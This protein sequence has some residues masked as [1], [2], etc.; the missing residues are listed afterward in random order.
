MGAGVGGNTIQIGD[1]QPIK[2]G[3]LAK[4]ITNYYL[5][6]KKIENVFKYKNSSQNN[7][8]YLSEWK[9]DKLY[10]LDYDWIRSWKVN[11]KYNDIKHELDQIYSTTKRKDLIKSLKMHCQLS[12]N[13]NILINYEDS[14]SFGPTSYSIFMSNN[15]LTLEDLDCLVD[16]ETYL[17]FKEMS[18]WNRFGTEIILEGIIS[19]KMIILFFNDI[20]IV[21]ILYNGMI[22]DKNEELIQL[23]AIAYHFV[24]ET[25]D[26][27]AEKT[28]LKYNKLKK[29]LKSKGENNILNIFE[30]QAIGY[31]EEIQLPIDGNDEIKI[32]NENLKSRNSRSIMQ[33]N[34]INQ[35][36]INFNNVNRERLIGLENVGATCY[37]NATLQCFINI[38]SL[39]QYLL[40]ESV[41]KQ[42]ENSDDDLYGLSKAY[43]HL[44]EKVCLDDNIKYYYAPREFKRVIS[45][46]NPLFQ[47]INAN[48]SKDLINFL[49]EVLNYE[50]S[51]FYCSKKDNYAKNS[52]MMD[53]TNMM[54]ILDNFRIEFTKNNKSIIAQN[55]FFILQ[56]NTVCNG[57][58]MLKYNF[59]SLF[60][61]EFPLEL[62]YNYSLSQ[63]LP[64]INNQGKKC[65]NL[66]T[67]FEHYGLPSKFTGENQ[68]YCNNCK[69]LRDAECKNILFSLPPVL[70]LIL[71]RGKGKSFDCDVDFPEFLN[72]QNF[73]NYKKSI[74]EYRLRGVISHLGES[75]MSGHFIAYCRHR[76]NNKWYCYNDATVTECQD[77]KNG[78]MNGTPY[79]LFYETINNQSNVLFDNVIDANLI[80][81]NMN[82]FNNDI[83]PFFNNLNQANNINL[84][85]NGI[86]LI[87]TN[88][89]NNFS[90]DMQMSNQMIQN[91]IN[92][93]NFNNI[94]NEN[95]N[96][97]SFQ[98]GNNLNNFRNIN[99]AQNNNSNLNIITNNINNFNNNF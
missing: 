33:S 93:F 34:Q 87:N 61:L 16:E 37:M 84:N 15:K 44:L 91:N 66:L 46:K 36:V 95:N 74:Y 29:L 60:L 51:Q 43:C 20:Q 47:G 78:F 18:F 92:N 49:L 97:I 86:N 26:F 67:C 98:S 75:G 62:V 1:I 9:I 81:D 38:N 54:L 11:S 14:F 22:E 39:T 71:N 24:G 8:Y 63:N 10:V 31:Q 45:E 70:V 25:D 5:F 89:S 2:I 52:V 58:H 21:K 40:T 7:N 13:A 83:N 68:L 77:Q 65:V 28:K 4:R 56:T 12:F 23:T 80:M 55:F 69:G 30:N 6:Q 57:C 53:P 50:L 94:N 64:L 85:N 42:I 19:N 73:I 96:N 79:I 90:F 17:S 41:Y 48:D 35:Q 27:D 3:P 76:I 59:Q 32:I 99:D 82:K 72:L 88:N